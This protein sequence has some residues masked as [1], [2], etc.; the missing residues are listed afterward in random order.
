MLLTLTRYLRKKLGTKLNK[1][2]PL[3]KSEKRQKLAQTL[4]LSVNSEF[5][6]KYIEILQ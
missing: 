2:N 6:F 5:R 3:Y 4:I 1:G